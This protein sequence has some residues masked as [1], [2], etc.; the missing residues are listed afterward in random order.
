MRLVCD[1]R[2]YQVL[3]VLSLYDTRSLC[4]FKCKQDM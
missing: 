3:K 1:T 4:S 2:V